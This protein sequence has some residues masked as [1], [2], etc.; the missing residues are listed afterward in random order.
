[1]MLEPRH[2]VRVR[3]CPQ[4]VR[5]SI[6]VTPSARRDSPSNRGPLA[7]RWPSAL[8]QSRLRLRPSRCL[9]RR[10]TERWFIAATKMKEAF[11]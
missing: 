4:T 10:S 9:P 11:S 6:P 8:L 7:R 1:M 3:F 2:E 5:S